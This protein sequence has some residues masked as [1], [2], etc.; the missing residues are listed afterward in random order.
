M[1]ASR[2]R[3]ERSGGTAPAPADRRGHPG[4]PVHHDLDDRRRPVRCAGRPA[5]ATRT[6]KPNP[7]VTR[8]GT[9]AEPE[10][11]VTARSLAGHLT[12]HLLNAIQRDSAGQGAQ[13]GPGQLPH[14][15]RADVQDRLGSQPLSRFARES[16]DRTRPGGRLDWTSAQVRPCGD[17]GRETVSG[18]VCAGSNPA[19]GALLNWPPPADLHF[20][21]FGP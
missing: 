19:G 6:S 14:R 10:R 8:P 3:D 13:Q 4:G 1:R 16:R 18:A 15:L 12:R 21:Q 11:V 7:A 9:F 20:R 5:G 17:L 2:R